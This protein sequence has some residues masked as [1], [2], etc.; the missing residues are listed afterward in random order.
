MYGGRAKV[1]TCENLKERDHL[2]D[3]SADGSKV[4]K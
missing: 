4:K 1:C 2:K 3:I